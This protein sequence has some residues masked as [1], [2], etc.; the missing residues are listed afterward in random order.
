MVTR[1]AAGP[2]EPLTA[3]KRVSPTHEVREQ[4]LAAIE[5]GQYAP[6]AP[7]PSERELCEIF[8]VSRVSVREAIAGLEA[9]NLIT[10]RHGLGAF[11]QQS[12]NER[13]AGSFAK[14]L[15]LHRDQLIELAKVRAPLEALAAEEAAR[16]ADPTALAIVQEAAV[17]FEEAVESADRARAAARDREFHLAIADASMGRLLPRMIHELN[18]LLTEAR[19]ATFAQQGQ[20]EQSVADH[21]AILE[22]LVRGDAD[23]ARGAVE[24]HMRRIGEWLAGLPDGEG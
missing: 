6:G 11:V 3:V 2:S 13:Y 5:S 14:Y 21:R 18:S 19:T 12:I 15:E 23:G 10:V 22:A 4:L 7:L 17:A 24:Q 8:G 16:H 1:R 9:M 20:L